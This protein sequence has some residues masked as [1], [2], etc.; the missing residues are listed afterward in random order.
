MEQQ[1]WRLGEHLLKPTINRFRK[2]YKKL[3]KHSGNLGQI[4]DVFE[5]LGKKASPR[6]P[7]SLQ[8]GEKKGAEF[9]IITQVAECCIALICIDSKSSEANAFSL[10]LI[11]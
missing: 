4:M 10:P 5:G 3:Q 9:C 8:K 6:I 2:Q 1:K 11:S 7:Y